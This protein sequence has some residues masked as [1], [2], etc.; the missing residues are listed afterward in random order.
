MTTPLALAGDAAPTLW[1]LVARAGALASRR[2]SDQTVIR[3]A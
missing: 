3:R 2:R 1:L